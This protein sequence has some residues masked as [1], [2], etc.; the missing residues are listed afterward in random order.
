VRKVG[1]GGVG[2]ELQTRLVV[3]LLVVLAPVVFAV[4][5][6]ER[7]LHLGVNICE[8]L[9][10]FADL[11]QNLQAVVM[12]AQVKSFLSLSNAAEECSVLPLFKSGLG[13]SQEIN[14]LN[15][16]GE[17]ARDQ[18][19]DNGILNGVELVPKRLHHFVVQAEQVLVFGLVKSG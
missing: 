17:L 2:Q 8:R 1:I 14:S 11:I 4:H 7:R 12:L 15:N 9:C 18:H 3:V 6:S 10:G 16:I 13:F 5:F 19:G